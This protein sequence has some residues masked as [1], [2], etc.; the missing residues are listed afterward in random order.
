MVSVMASPEVHLSVLHS[1]VMLMALPTNIK[2][3][4]NLMRIN[5][6]VYLEKDLKIFGSEF[7]PKVCNLK[8]QPQ[9]KFLHF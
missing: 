5:D 7:S 8:R 3:I 2:H 4:K 9:I 6:L 1:M